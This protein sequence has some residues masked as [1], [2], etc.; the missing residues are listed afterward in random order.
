[1]ETK[2]V[3]PASVAHLN[4][5]FAPIQDEI[6]VGPLEVVQGSIR[7]ELTGIYLCNGPTCRFPPS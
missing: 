1:M 3:D 2:P 4:G 7:R 6:D 5:I